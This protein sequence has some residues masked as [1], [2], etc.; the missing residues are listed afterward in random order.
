MYAVVYCHELTWVK[1]DDSGCSW[2]SRYSDFMSYRTGQVPRSGGNGIIVNDAISYSFSW[3]G[4]RRRRIASKFGIVTI[5]LLGQGVVIWDGRTS[6]WHV[7]SG[8]GGGRFSSHDV[9]RAWLEWLVVE[10]LVV[11]SGEV[12][13]ISRPLI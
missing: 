9:S 5:R 10:S 4:S 8:R 6:E 3:G 12:I 1:V 11:E 13:V 7:K 2:L